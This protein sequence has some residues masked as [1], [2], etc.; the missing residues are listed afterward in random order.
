MARM[1]DWPRGLRWNRI[2]ALNGPESVGAVDTQSIGDM[3]QTVA[4]PFGARYMQFSFPPIKGMMARR[5]RGLVTS[6]HKGVNAV[7][8]RI[9]DADGLSFEEAGM[10]PTELQIRRG[11]PWSNGLPWS[12][13][14]NWK[15]SK[16]N[17]LVETAAAKDASFVKLKDEFW[18]R[19]LGVGDWIG[20]FPLHFGMYEITQ[21][22]DDDTYRIWPPLRKAITVDTYAT[23][24]PVLAMRLLSSNLPDADRGPSHLEGLTMSLFEVPDYYVRQY[25][26]E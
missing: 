4:S 8:V 6:L 23:L 1:L 19:Q 12:N 25:F 26:T 22:M 14:E 2:K 7:R 13:G 10:T 5:A 9:C 15:L 17:V 16:P 24:Y 18:G 11:M 21:L 20:F 3:T